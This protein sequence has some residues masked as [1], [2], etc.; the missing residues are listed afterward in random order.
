MLHRSFS[1]II[2]RSA[3]VRTMIYKRFIVLPNTRDAHT[4][5]YCCVFI[6][7]AEQQATHYSIMQWD[8]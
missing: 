4:Y 5:V 6:F 2:H 3:D 7:P 8:K 1:T